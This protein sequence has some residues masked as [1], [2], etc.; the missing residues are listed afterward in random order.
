MEQRRANK[1]VYGP[2][3]APTMTLPFTALS[4]NQQR[5]IPALDLTQILITKQEGHIT[6]AAV[7]RSWPH[8]N[9]RSIENHAHP[10]NGWPPRA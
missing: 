8:F 4:H 6:S 1:L 7:S 3:A 10:S 5:V 9:R 2:W